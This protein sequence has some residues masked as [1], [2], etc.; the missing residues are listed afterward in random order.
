MN[1]SQG[2]FRFPDGPKA[3]A[4]QAAGTAVM[5]LALLFIVSLATTF[6][7]AA[8]RGD[9]R[10]SGLN[11]FPKDDVYRLHFAG[12]WLMDGLGNALR[13]Q[14][15]RLG[16]V[17][18]QSDKIDLQSL[19]RSGWNDQVAAIRARAGVSNIDVAVVFFGV[20]E[21]GPLYTPGRN[22]QRFGNETWLKRYA[23]RVDAT[24]KALKVNKGAV[25]WLGLPITRR[26]DQSEAYQ[27]I[28]TLARERAYANGVTYIDVFS[29]FQGDNGGFNRYGP[30]LD[31]TIK[32]LRTKDGVNF[33]SRGY[34]KIAHLVMQA[35]RRDLGRVKNER[36]VSLAGSESE[37]GSIR[38]ARQAAQ[39]RR[40]RPPVKDTAKSDKPKKAVA[41]G[42]VT[43]FGG[44]K[45][46]DGSFE[47]RTVANSKPVKINLKLPRPALSGAIVSLVTR[48]TSKD[49]PA[50]FGDN[51]VG[52]ADGGIPLLSTVT[53]ADESALALRRRRLSPT[54][55]VF[56]KVW[57]KGERLTPKP[58]RADDFQWPRPDPKPVVHARAEAAGAR[59]A[60]FRPEVSRR[61]PSLPP[62][63]QKNP[64]R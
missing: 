45:A 40:K 30:D 39:G 50:R 12:D 35:I 2:S 22:R 15:A 38:R 37:Q 28:N 25:Y 19:R 16:R 42:G 53:P 29:R 11:P 46:D 41:T 49:K 17:Q 47:F 44:L 13:P 5:L 34:G 54:Q 4:V 10:N 21:I 63:P 52:I 48:N 8:Q 9:L 43:Q 32:L 64:L 55:S 33:T 23:A 3:P 58:G 59:R 18:V 62:L 51:A 36:V 7:A 20:N 56:F 1:G 6:P 61:D 57:G 14:L 27:I 60:R 24:M 26:R 31:G